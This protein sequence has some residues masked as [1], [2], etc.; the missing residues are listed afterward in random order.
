MICYIILYFILYQA[1]EN[2]SI[3][4]NAGR[5]YLLRNILLTK[6]E[7]RTG[8]LISAIG[9][10]STDRAQRCPYKEGRTGVFS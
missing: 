6:R 9:H 8:R 10:G 1:I 2:E 5:R 3:Q 7:D 4:L